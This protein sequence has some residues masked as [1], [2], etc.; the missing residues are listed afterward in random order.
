MNSTFFPWNDFSR[1]VFTLAISLCNQL[2]RDLRGILHNQILLC[3]HLNFRPLISFSYS[4]TTRSVRWCPTSLPA[5]WMTMFLGIFP[6]TRI[7]S[8]LLRIKGN[9]APGKLYTVL[10]IPLWCRRAP[11]PLTNDVPMTTVSG[12]RSRRAPAYYNKS[13][14]SRSAGADYPKLAKHHAC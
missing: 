12:R 7:L 9:W 3:G 1:K 2:S 4:L 5:A 8:S 6:G 14:Y 13:V 10:S 11:T